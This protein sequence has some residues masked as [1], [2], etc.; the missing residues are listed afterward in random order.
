MLRRVTDAWQRQDPRLYQIAVLAGLF[1]YGVVWL[2][3]AVAGIGILL[4]FVLLP[5]QPQPERLVASMICLAIAS[6]WFWLYAR[7]GYRISLL[8]GLLCALAIVPCLFTWTQV[9][10]LV[11]IVLKVFHWLFG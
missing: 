1:G 2:N 3:F 11:Q 10:A 6:F 4:A 8:L 5:T 9:L 7:N